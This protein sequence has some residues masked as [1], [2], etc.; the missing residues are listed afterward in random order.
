MA[1]Q[2]S[3]VACIVASILTL[4]AGP[5]AAKRD[6]LTVRLSAAT[7]PS[8]ADVIVHARVEPDERSR[9][10]VIEWVAGDLS[11]GSHLITLDG[12]RAAVI[13]Q[14]PIKDMGPGEYVVTAILRLMDGTEIRRRSS[15]TVV[16]LDG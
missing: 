4:F 12:A 13:H 11:G 9:E 16:G 7:S 2:V 6:A 15:V 5:V 3:R 8:R 1:S 10:L 14:Y